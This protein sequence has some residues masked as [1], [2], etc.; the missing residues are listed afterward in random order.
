MRKYL[1]FLAM[2]FAISAMAQET[3]DTAFVVNGKTIKVSD[4]KGTTTVSVF[5]GSGDNMHKTAQYNFT[6]SQEVER[7]YVS[8][9][10]IPEIITQG[11]RKENSRKVYRRF[12]SNYPLFFI[13]YNQAAAGAFDFGG[14]SKMYSRDSKSWEWGLTLAAT[15]I[16]LN[17]NKTLG[18]TAAWQFGQVHHHFKNNYA[19][20]TDMNHSYMAPVDGVELKKSYISYDVWRLPVMLEMQKKNFFVGFG[21]S[22]E[23]RW[24]EHSRYIKRGGGKVTLSDDINMNP[25]GVNLDLKAGVGSFQIYMRGALTPLLK[26]DIAPKCFPL[27]VGMGFKL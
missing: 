10:L 17:K 7:I 16:P 19:L 12:R 18:I 24:N 21:A 1:L 22:L 9:P 15:A 2:S 14:N 4:K 27:T 20:F 25:L 6:D 26:N 11:K 23:Y 5:N 3:T 13:G 8:T